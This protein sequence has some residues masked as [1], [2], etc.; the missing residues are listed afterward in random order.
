MVQKF[1][2]QVL[3][4]RPSEVLEMRTWSPNTQYITFNNAEITKPKTPEPKI[5]RTRNIVSWNQV[6]KMF[7][8]IPPT[9]VEA[10]GGLHR[11]APIPACSIQCLFQPFSASAINALLFAIARYRP[12][13]VPLPPKSR[14]WTA[15]RFLLGIPSGEQVADYNSWIALDTMSVMTFK[16]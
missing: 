13:S 16:F 11:R 7:C 10:F 14:V 5:H 4:S 9:Y 2:S 8:D 6:P 3:D 15:S 1:Y 12:K